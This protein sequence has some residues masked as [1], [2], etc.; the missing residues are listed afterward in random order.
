MAFE[1]KHKRQNFRTCNCCWWLRPAIFFFS[2]LTT[3]Y[4]FFFHVL[5]FQAVLT[6]QA[7][8]STVQ[9]RFGN[10]S[11]G[12]PQL[13]CAFQSWRL[14]GKTLTQ[15]QTKHSPTWHL[16]L[17]RRQ[18][19]PMENKKGWG[20]GLILFSSVIKVNQVFFENNATVHFFSSSLIIPYSDH[21][22]LV[23]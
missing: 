13:L 6:K 14:H 5:L 8:K 17:L 11:S 19:S 22:T 15:I 16:L 20:E 2:C 1:N 4:F 3:S 7:K 18:T 21:W 9:N 23:L 10:S 12:A